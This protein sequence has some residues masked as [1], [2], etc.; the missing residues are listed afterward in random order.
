MKTKKTKGRAS[1]AGSRS[2]PLT[3]GLSAIGF[4]VSE[5]RRIDDVAQHLDVQVRT[6]YR[7]LQGIERAGLEVQVRRDG[8]R[9]FHRIATSSLKRALGI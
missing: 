5:E 3:V 9:V 7:V 2:D 8:V 1:K 4:L 6:A